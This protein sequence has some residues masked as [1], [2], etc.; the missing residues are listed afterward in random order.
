M[1]YRNAEIVLGHALYMPDLKLYQV[2]IYI[3]IMAYIGEFDGEPETVAFHN[4]KIFELGKDFRYDYEWVTGY[5]DISMR[6]SKHM[7]IKMIAV[8]RMEFGM[9]DNDKRD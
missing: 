1:K 6:I 3:G 5:R 9:I 4:I 7:I 8:I 2:L